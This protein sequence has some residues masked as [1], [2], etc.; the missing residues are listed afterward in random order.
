MPLHHVVNIFF[1]VSGLQFIFA[2]QNQFSFGQKNLQEIKKSMFE[3]QTKSHHGCNF[4]NAPGQAVC[5]ILFKKTKKSP[6]NYLKSLS[7]FGTDFVCQ[8]VLSIKIDPAGDNGIINHVQ[9]TP[10][11]RKGNLVPPKGEWGGRKG[12]YGKYRSPFSKLPQD[13]DH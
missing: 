12:E 6:K 11:I 2:V 7:H 4:P 9:K 3:K 1:S 5:W 8:L 13:F 10:Q